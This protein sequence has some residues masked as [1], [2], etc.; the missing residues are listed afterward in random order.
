[1]A[2]PT[3]IS[4]AYSA[5]SSF[6]HALISERSFKPWCEALLADRTRVETAFMCVAHK[7]RKHRAMDRRCH[8]VRFAGLEA[9]LLG[10]DG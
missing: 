1:M 2:G 5:S 3:E 7:Q 4:K 6:E 10:M 8:G 9:T